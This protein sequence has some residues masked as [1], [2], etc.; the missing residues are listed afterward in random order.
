MLS[1]RVSF[2][3]PNRLNFRK[4]PSDILRLIFGYLEEV[5]DITNVSLV[6]KK[7]NTLVWSCVKKLAICLRKKSPWETLSKM[8]RLRTL[9]IDASNSEIVKQER[10]DNSIG[11]LEDLRK[12]C[13]ERCSNLLRFQSLQK[14]SHLESLS[15]YDCVK[16]E[17]L[18]FLNSAKKLRRLCLSKC[19]LSESG[20]EVLGT[21]YP[22]QRL[23]LW[24]TSAQDSWVV[25]LSKLTNL[26]TLDISGNQTLT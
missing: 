15:L 26:D 14:L 9:E 6:N 13:I 10:I 24:H 23:Y 17:D 11:K 12:L 22:L 1:C 5:R 20:F 7:W 18:S 8:T 19:M 16:I 4:V 2:S 3:L 21:L 25:K